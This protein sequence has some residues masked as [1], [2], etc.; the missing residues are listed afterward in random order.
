MLPT[1][2]SPEDASEQLKWWI[3]NDVQREAAARQAQARHRRPG[4]HRVPWRLCRDGSGAE[5]G[6]GTLRE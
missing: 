5:S 6:C 3:E 2:A 4:F 1:F